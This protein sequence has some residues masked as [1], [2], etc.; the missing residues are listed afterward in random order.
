[1]K[2]IFFIF[3]TVVSKEGPYQKLVRG[4]QLICVSH[5]K[6]SR[7]LTKLFQNNEIQRF[8]KKIDGQCDT[9]KYTIGW[10]PNPIFGDVPCINFDIT[11]ILKD[12]PPPHNKIGQRSILENIIGLRDV[13]N[14]FSSNMRIQF[15]VGLFFN[16]KLQFKTKQ[17]GTSWNSHHST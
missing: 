14:S 16:K 6:F 9:P 4:P 7:N 2:P 3:L 1:V 13:R 10:N 5:S 12:P 15:L 17:I 11:K 8:I